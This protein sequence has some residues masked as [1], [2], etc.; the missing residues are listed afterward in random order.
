MRALFHCKAK[1][2]Y[3]ICRAQSKRKMLTKSI[4]FFMA[5]CYNALWMDNAQVSQSSSQDILGIGIRN[6]REAPTK[7]PVRYAVL[8]CCHPEEEGLLCPTLR[9][10]MSCIWPN[11]PCAQAPSKKKEWWQNTGLS[12]LQW[13]SPIAALERTATDAKQEEKKSEW[14]PGCLKVRN[15][16]RS[17]L[18]KEAEDSRSRVA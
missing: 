11:S 7:T 13:G 2:S 6:G 1:A 17:T 14:G 10:H 4:F 15:G 8:L 18:P 5:Y 12:V 3:I 9:A 16:Q